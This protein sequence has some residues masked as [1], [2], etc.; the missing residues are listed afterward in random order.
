[1]GMG[2]ARRARRAGARLQHKATTRKRHDP[3]GSWRFFCCPGV[4]VPAIS[5]RILRGSL[6]AF[7]DPF[8]PERQGRQLV[9]RSEVTAKAHV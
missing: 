1:M 8:A 6:R 9:R 3:G 7:T 4:S 5:Q 2:M